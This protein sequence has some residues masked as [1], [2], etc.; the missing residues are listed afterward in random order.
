MK[1]A[2]VL[3]LLLSFCILSALLASPLSAWAK[4]GEASRVVLPSGLTLV[5]KEYHKIPIADFLLILPGGASQET[6]E[7]AGLAA[8]T[9]DLLL[10]GTLHRNARQ[11]S[12]EIDFL[13]GS[14]SASANYDYCSLSLEVLSKDMD[15]GLDLFLD[16]LLHPT[17]PQEELE[18]QRAQALAALSQANEEPAVIA[19]RRFRSLLFQDHPY[20]H[21]LNG[22]RQ[23]LTSI[24]REDVEAFYRRFFLPNQAI[25]VVVGHF[26]ADQMAEKLKGLFSSWPRGELKLDPI[27]SP[28]P[29]RGRRVV[30]VDKPDVTQAQILMGNIGP[31]RDTPRFFPLSLANGILG[32]MGFSSRLMDQ[33]RANLGLTYGIDS[34]FSMGKAG[35]SF[36]IE[37]STQTENVG[38]AIS[39]ILEELRVFRERGLTPEELTKVKTYKRGIYYIALERAG[40]LV[41]QLADMAFY[42]LPLDYIDTYQEK[43]DAVTLEEANA[44][45]RDLFPYENL[46]ILI[47]GNAEK[48]KGQLQGLGWGRLEIEK[49]QPE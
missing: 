2:K 26:Q 46:L 8:F 22:T 34:S 4:L 19:G 17:F 6:S 25:L 3:A 49:F 24:D 32:R 18:R 10:K 33:I 15:R 7:K 5:L 35:G 27:P 43:S 39:A 48:I 36:L 38:K 1:R 31:S 47:L 42:G 29:F 12:E 23:S 37:T 41:G 44:A 13:G 28:T 21:P 20:G 14:L 11:I 9:A 16:C 30:L 40:A 45:A